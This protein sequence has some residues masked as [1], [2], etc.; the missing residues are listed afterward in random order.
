MEV[1]HDIMETVIKTGSPAPNF[2]LYSLD[3][4]K[5][6]LESLR[7]KTIVLNFWSAECPWSARADQTLKRMLK[8]WGKQVVVLTLASNANETREMLQQAA[9]QREIP[10]LLLDSDQQ[11]SRLYGA[12]ITPQVYVIDQQGLLRYQGAFDD[13]NFRNPEPTCNYLWDAVETTL[14]GKIPA[15]G[16]RPA[17]GCTIVF[18]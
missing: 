10:H 9:E 15:P 16:E 8:T 18:A 14:A 6:T 11:V 2:T 12:Q 7:G 13:A 17:Y 5:Y 4:R 3:G 1:M